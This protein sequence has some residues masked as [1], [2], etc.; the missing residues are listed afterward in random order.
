M[1]EELFLVVNVEVEVLYKLED[2][3]RPFVVE[4]IKLL[5]GKH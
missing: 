4:L 5:V 3:L 1:A 2:D